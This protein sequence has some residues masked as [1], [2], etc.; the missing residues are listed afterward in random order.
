MERMTQEA[1][2]LLEAALAR[3]N[4]ARAWRRVKA[5][6]GSAGVDG[7]SI[8]AS[9]DYLALHW[10]Q[11]RQQLLD[12]TY[13]PQPV[14]RVQIPK[15]DG[16][17]RDLGIPTVTDRLIQQALHRADE[18]HGQ[19]HQLTGHLLLAARHLDHLAVDPFDMHGAQRRGLA[20]MKHRFTTTL[21]K[22][23]IDIRGIYSAESFTETSSHTTDTA[24]DFHHGQICR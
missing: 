9:S 15:P 17:K 8:A 18:A 6:K 14:R 11:I 2:M 5:N 7:L 23:G 19:H 10:P 3:E 22:C 20:V 13:R 21:E 12:G 24:T 1:P 4:V 16:S